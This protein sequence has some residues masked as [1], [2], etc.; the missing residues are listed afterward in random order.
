MRA[1]FPAGGLGEIYL[2]LERTGGWSTQRRVSHVYESDGKQDRLL[3]TSQGGMFTRQDPGNSALVSPE[4]EKEYAGFLTT[5]IQQDIRRIEEVR[6]M[7]V[8]LSVMQRKGLSEN[9]RS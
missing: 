2:R 1:L 8:N 4:Q 3:W 6:R 7:L 5:L 9:E